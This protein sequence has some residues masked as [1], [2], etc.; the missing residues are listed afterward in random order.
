[1]NNI[2]NILNNYNVTLEHIINSNSPILDIKTYI[3]NL[4][5]DAI[6]RAYIKYITKK[7]GINYTLVI[8]KP[9]L[10]EIK[11]HMHIIGNVQ[12]GVI[13]CFLSHMWCIKNAIENNHDYFLIYEDDI[14]F[15]KDFN[16]LIKKVNYKKYDM[17][18][19][20]CCDFNLKRNIENKSNID[21][22]IYNPK[23]IALGAYGNIYNKNFAKLVYLEK[24]NN[25][26]EFD[27]TFDMYYFK[28]NI[29]ICLPNLIT[30]ELSTTNLGHN[31]SI[32]TAYNNQFITSCFYDFNYNDYFFIW[33]IFIEFCY[34]YSKTNID[35]ISNTYTNVI[36][37]FA[38][39]TS[40]KL[41][42]N[43]NIRE[44]NKN[45]ED[46]IKNILLNNGIYAND[47]M[48]ILKTI[49]TDNYN[50]T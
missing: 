14:V 50:T 6:R 31:F 24:I 44:N 25:F 42:K 28:Y 4:E 45:I 20:G 32:F 39:E 38:L 34:N 35:N 36:N 37:K 27:T 10:S 9:I 33:I 17:I 3:I 47:M 18:Q 29:G 40:S 15:H 13:G 7:L 19:L 22:T 1:M 30:A 43:A 26:K 46:L 41:N 8:V 16:S 48:Y 21:M 5:S 12:N 11:K 49:D 23:Q 2:V